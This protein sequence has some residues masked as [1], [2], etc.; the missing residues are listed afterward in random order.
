MAKYDPLRAYLDTE[1]DP[2]VTL[3]FE[4]VANLVSGLPPSAFNYRAWWANDAYHVQA[5]AWGA[6]GW[7]V[8]FVDLTK[9]V[10]RFRRLI[11]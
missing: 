1:A 6:A 3:D 10:V 8:D 9:C 4:E 2:A 5:A 11:H 7:S